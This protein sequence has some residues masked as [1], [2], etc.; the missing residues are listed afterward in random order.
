ME[1]KTDLNDDT[2]EQIQRLI[3]ANL[4]SYEGYKDAAEDVKNTRLRELF[5]DLAMT[6]SRQAAS[7]QTYITWN[8]ETPE[9]EG[10]IRGAIHRAWMNARTAINS[11]D[12][13]VVL[14]EASRGEEHIKELYEDVIKDIPGNALSD[15]LH[16]QYAAVKHDYTRIEALKKAYN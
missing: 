7:L 9:E 13:E 6:R 8:D 1:T 5:N 14:I 15:V 10:T 11:G 16:S 4:D 2:I 12:E 3:Q